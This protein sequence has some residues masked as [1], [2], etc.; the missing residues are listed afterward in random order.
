MFVK[1]KIHLEE[2]KMKTIVFSLVILL[3]LLNNSVSYSQ[4]SVSKEKRKW[5]DHIF[6]EN[7][8]FYKGSPSLEFS[9]G[10]SDISLKNFQWI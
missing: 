9:Y 1:V 5:K 10:Q 8:Y 3:V 7:D 2:I 6:S 4:D